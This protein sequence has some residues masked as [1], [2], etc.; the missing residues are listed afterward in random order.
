MAISSKVKLLCY[1]ILEESTVTVTAVDSGYP[2]ERLFDRSLGFYCQ[3]SVASAYVVSVYQG[4]TILPVDTLIIE[5]HI[6]NGVTVD[7][8]YSDNGSSW[9]NAVPQWTQSDNSQI[10]KQSAAASSHRW[11]RVS[12]GSHLFQ[13]TEIFMGRALSVPVVWGNQPRLGDTADVEKIRTYGG[14]DHFIRVGPKRKQREYTVFMDRVNYPVATFTSDL[15]YL[16]DYSKPF[17]IIDHEGTCFL[18]EFGNQPPSAEHMNQGLMEFG[19]S[20]SE[21]KG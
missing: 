4:G 5:D 21:V 7:W 14:V 10:F 20:V 8:Q 12:M 17:Y 11:W 18:T 16:D 9:T 3:Y 13:S 6:L 2:K 1:N 15:E 19:I